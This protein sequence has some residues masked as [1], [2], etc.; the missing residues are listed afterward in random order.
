MIWLAFAVLTG[1]AI[2]AVTRPLARSLTAASRDLSEVE[3]YKL[4]L[5]E[6]GRD[7]ERGTLGKEEAEQT[8]TEIARRLLKANRQKGVPAGADSRFNANYAF[9]VLAAVIATGSAGLYAYFGAAGE[10]DQP[11]EARLSAPPDR[12]PLGIQI[13]NVERRLRANPNDALGWSVLAPVYFKT[14]QF[15]KAANAYRKAIELSG[16][17][18]ERLYGLFESLT[19]ASSGVV[20]PDAKA[21]LS[22]ALIKNPKSLRGRFWQAILADQ[23]GRKADAEQIYLDMLSENIAP[24]WK[25]VVNQRLEALRGEPAAQ[26]GFGD[27]A[28]GD[29]SAMIR[30]M[31]ERL[32]ARLKENGADLDGWLRLIRSYAVLKEMDK[33][34]EAAASARQQFVSEPQALEQIESLAS[35]LGLPGQ[36]SRAASTQESRTGDNAQADQGAIIRGMA[37]RL[38][39]RLKENGADLNGWLM[40]IRTYAVLQDK[41]KA[42]EAVASARQQFA[43]EPQALEQIESLTHG[44]GLDSLEAKAGQPRS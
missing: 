3:A 34:R 2:L 1:C 10:P 18:E 31:V 26:P 14:E 23:E 41:G 12:Q 33:A 7:V 13:A 20:P 40:L 19:F 43:S 37:G 4:Q 17:D 27:N 42:Q 6:L 11:L 8:R 32:A 44:L 28:E 21:A 36:G 39:A 30:G 22:G 5:D 15:G 38:A 35:T 29:R 16:E 25:A 9:F 24:A